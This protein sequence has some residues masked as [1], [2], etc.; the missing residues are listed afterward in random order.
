MREHLGQPVP[1][2]RLQLVSGDEKVGHAGGAYCGERGPDRVG[3]LAGGPVEDLVP[4]AED[5]VLPG[6]GT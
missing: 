3:E 2:A 5:E 4:V 6:L 1:V